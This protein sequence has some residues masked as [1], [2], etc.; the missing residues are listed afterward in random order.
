MSE[1]PW[2][3]AGLKFSCQQDCGAC[4]TDHEDYAYVYIDPDEERAMAEF[5][6]LS[7]RQFRRRWTTLDEGHRV[8]RMDGPDCPFL[9]GSRCSIY[10]V[11]PSQCRTFPFWTE[12][13]SSPGAWK[14]LREFCPGIDVGE[15][16]PLKVIRKRLDER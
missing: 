13:L 16:H 15:K 10:P 11:R 9:D 4:C 3:A 5:L 7:L 2:Y 12:N 6:E 8:L 1:S 14:A